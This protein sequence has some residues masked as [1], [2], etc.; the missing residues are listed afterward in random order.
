MNQGGRR[1]KW[2][3]YQFPFTI[4]HFAQLRGD[5]YLRHG[6]K[7]SKVVKDEQYDD[8]VS[9]NSVI[10]WPWLNFRSPGRDKMMM[11]FDNV[12]EGVASIEVGFNQSDL[13]AFT[14]PFDIPADSVPGEIIPL[15]VS[16]PTFSI[17]LTYKSDQIWEWNALQVY[18]EDTA[19][20][21]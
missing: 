5:L 11:G 10:Q 9:F 4:E 18:V 15:P 16:G 20:G 2:S 21:T 17:K 6:D 13:T 7:V 3:R 19:I 1:G 14:A 8:G 12:G